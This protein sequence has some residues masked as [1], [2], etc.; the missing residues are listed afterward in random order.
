MKA[1][2]RRLAAA[3]SE[4]DV[5]SFVF[6]RIHFS[7][8]VDDNAAINKVETSLLAGS[9]RKHMATAFG[10]LGPASSAFT[11][12]VNFLNKEDTCCLPHV[13]T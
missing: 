2:T 8:V 4:H 12:K 9:G 7:A 6:D 1:I 3:F 13:A 11:L 5:L 10:S